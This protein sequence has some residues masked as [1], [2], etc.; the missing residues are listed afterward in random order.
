MPPL[1]PSLELGGGP[2]PAEAAYQ[3]QLPGEAVALAPVRL[4]PPLLRFSRSK[5]HQT[6]EARLLQ[7]GDR[8]RVRGQG[9]RS[10]SG[11]RVRGQGQG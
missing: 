1:T 11:V 4:R 7:P 9:Q 3:E 8:G 10:E 5:L 2:A 6:A